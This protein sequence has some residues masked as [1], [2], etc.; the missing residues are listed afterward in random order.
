M[1]KYQSIVL[2][3]ASSGIGRALAEAVAARGRHLLLI[4][5][6]EDRL[7]EAATAAQARGAEVETATVDVTDRAGMLQLLR[8]F[9]GR[10]PV[11]LILANAG[12][13]AGLEPG[14]MPEAEGVSYRLAQIN[15]LGMLNSVEP[16]LPA[17][18][19]RG[20]GRIALMASLAGLRPHPDMP[21]YSATK[22]AVRA[23]GTAMRGAMRSHGIGVTVINPGFVTSPMAN[24]H[25]GFKPFEIPADAAA[26]RIL[27]GLAEDKPLITFPWPLALL[28]W[29]GNRM[30]PGLS[31]LAVKGF[32]ADIAPED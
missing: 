13:S 30:P 4:A 10:H 15:Y 5:R 22:A 27:H 29:L 21:S 9:D 31:D 26:E 6:N 25:H 28:I 3:G 18:I 23:W 7:A 24:R 12:V 19:A 17:M 14:Q 11:D 20:R 2:T 1:T 32:R 16:L 8:D